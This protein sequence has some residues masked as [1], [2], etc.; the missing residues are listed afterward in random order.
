MRGDIC[1]LT[2]LKH[3]LMDVYMPWTLES[4]VSKS[5]I[6]TPRSSCS[7]ISDSSIRSTTM[8]KSYPWT[9]CCTCWCTK[10]VLLTSSGASGFQATPGLSGSRPMYLSWNPPCPSEIA[11]KWPSVVLSHLRTFASVD[12]SFRWDAW[13][14]NTRDMARDAGFR[15]EPSK[16]EALLSRLP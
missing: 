8:K 16:N 4:N 12:S 10:S 14:K 2:P 9:I 13:V 1:A 11:P 7:T 15:I 3:S 6:A 5:P